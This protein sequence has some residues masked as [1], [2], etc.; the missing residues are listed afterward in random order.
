MW[1]ITLGSLLLTFQ[2]IISSSRIDGNTKKH[3][4]CSHLMFNR[5]YSKDL[6]DSL[7]INSAG[8]IL[9]ACVIFLLI[10][11]NSILIVS[12]AISPTGCF[13]VVIEGL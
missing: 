2:S 10:R 13:I 8:K 9:C 5:T 11:S 1:M 7:T 6:V 12:S 3:Q 4:A